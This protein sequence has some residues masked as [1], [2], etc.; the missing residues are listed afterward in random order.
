MFQRI[1]PLLLILL[2][3]AA[4]AQNSSVTRI[5]PVNVTASV[6]GVLNDDSP[7]AVIYVMKV[8]S[9]D[10][11]LEK[12]SEVLIR[13]YFSTKPTKGD[14]ELPGVKGGDVIQAEIAGKIDPISGQMEYTVFRYS[15]LPTRTIKS[16]STEVNDQ[17]HK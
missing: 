16:S 13:F 6:V 14:P 1:L 5:K 17:P 11:G 7:L 9:N 12:S 4:K 2:S 3:F 10:I 15:I 8:D